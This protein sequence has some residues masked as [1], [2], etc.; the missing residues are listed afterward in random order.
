[1]K[2]VVTLLVVIFV[3][4]IPGAVMAGPPAT[5]GL[6]FASLEDGLE[7][8]YEATQKIP[9][10]VIE[11]LRDIFPPPQVGARTLDFPP[12]ALEHLP[13]SRMDNQNS[14]LQP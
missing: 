3:L 13:Q 9:D 14:Y 12:R 5:P 10:V 4:S 11:S 8:N 6:P 7:R 1:M 2:H